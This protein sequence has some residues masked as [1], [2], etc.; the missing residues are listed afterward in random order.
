MNV[1]FHMGAFFTNKR[2]IAK[3]LEAEKEIDEK[4]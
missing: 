3:T 2:I 4:N 1:I